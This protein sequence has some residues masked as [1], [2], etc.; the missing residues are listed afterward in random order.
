[1]RKISFL[2][3]LVILV[4]GLMVVQTA[5]AVD[6]GSSSL[7]GTLDYADTY[8]IPGAGGRD[9]TTV[10]GVGDSG[11][12]QNTVEQNFSN[13]SQQWQIVSGFAHRDT[14]TSFGGLGAGSGNAGAATGFWETGGG[15]VGHTYGVRNDY[16]VQVDAILP[17][18]RLN[19]TSGDDPFGG[20]F[21]TNSLAVFFRR[22]G[23]TNPEIGLFNGTTETDTG[24]STGIGANDNNWHNYAVRF[25]QVDDEI[26][27]YVDENL[28]GTLDLATFAGG[29]YQNYSNGTVGH[30]GTF[31]TEVDNYQVGS[32]I[33]EP[34][35]IAL[36]GLGGLMLLRRK[37]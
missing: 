7:I 20:I 26:S 16:V 35:S 10:Y 25:N 5:H 6:V 9:N 32:F 36:L 37:H 24:F 22:D 8:T 33:P 23:A 12:A 2:N 11:L 34:A 4:G 14:T 1:M 28:V 29:I 21:G 18:D 30:G 3:S 13:P 27:F 15:E 31:V 19:I 17:G